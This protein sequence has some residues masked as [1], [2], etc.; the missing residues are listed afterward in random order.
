MVELLEGIG[1][2]IRR[3]RDEKG[4]NQTELG[5]HADTSPS[6]ISLVENGK[7][8]PSTATLA[9]IAGA[10]G[11][12]VVDLFPKQERRSLSEPSF[13]D[14]DIERHPSVLA[15]AV[16]A[17][18]D[19]WM[20]EIKDPN[21]SWQTIYQAAEKVLDLQD[22]ISTRLE[23]EGWWKRLSEQERHDIV[24]VDKHL[25]ALATAVYRRQLQRS[26]DEDD[27]EQDARHEEFNR[28]REHIKEITRQ[29]S[30]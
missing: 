20:R 21:A 9:K 23:K 30:A 18:A 24:Y 8:N 15:E 5:F 2:N 17:A 11:V 26:E 7:R 6:I 13:D 4:W 16:V 27:V 19:I 10:L 25:D 1:H 14:V 3:L 29:I 12:E 22:Y 28:R